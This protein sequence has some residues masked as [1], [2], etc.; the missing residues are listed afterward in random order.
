MKY[1]VEIMSGSMKIGK[2]VRKFNREG[3][4]IEAHRQQSKFL[5]LLLLLFFSKERD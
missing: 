3:I 2:G 1:G 4:A 5:S